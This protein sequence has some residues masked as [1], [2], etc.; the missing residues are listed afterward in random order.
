MLGM[1]RP[2]PFARPCWVPFQ[3]L[4]CHSTPTLSF[5]AFSSLSDMWGCIGYSTFLIFLF[6]FFGKCVCVTG[7]S[8]L[9]FHIT[10]P[11][12]ASPEGASEREAEARSACMRTGYAG[13]M[14]AVRPKLP[15]QGRAVQRLRQSSLPKKQA[16]TLNVGR[17]LTVALPSMYL[18]FE[19]KINSK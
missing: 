16:G 2:C 7:G 10:N 14:Y 15:K 8:P 1:P 18:L 4:L 17:W 9:L 19:R 3:H 5:H 13:H 11:V 12:V 6:S